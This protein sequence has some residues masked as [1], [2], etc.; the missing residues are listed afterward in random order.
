MKPDESEPEASE[1]EPRERPQEA[2]DQIDVDDAYEVRYWTKELVVTE[3]E[4]RNAIQNV[5]PNVADVRRALGR[6][7]GPEPARGTQPGP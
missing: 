6:R 4:L 5:G 1:T 2:R 3:Q 7:E